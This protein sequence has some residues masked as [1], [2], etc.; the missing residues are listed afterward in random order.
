METPVHEGENR[1][2]SGPITCSRSSHSQWMAELI[3]S[4]PSC[5]HPSPLFARNSW[6]ISFSR[7]MAIG[8][9]F[10]IVVL[11]TAYWAHYIGSVIHWLPGLLMGSACLDVWTVGVNYTEMKS[12]YN[13]WI[14]NFDL[15]IRNTNFLNN[16]VIKIA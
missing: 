2:F 14:K 3:F 4:H 6:P 16:Q 9:T 12:L 15:S 1:A 11:L 5:W 13:R 8:E 10:V 7:A